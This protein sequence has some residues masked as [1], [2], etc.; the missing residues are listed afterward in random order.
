M[1]NSVTL[2]NAAAIGTGG[3]AVGLEVWA[4]GRTYAVGAR[5]ISPSGRPIVCRVAH[6]S[7]STFNATRW[8]Y[9]GPL[10]ATIVDFTLLPDGNIATTEPAFGSVS[11]FGVADQYLYGYV[12]KDGAAQDWR[13][14]NPANGAPPSQSY[15]TSYLPDTTEN[16]KHLWIEYEVSAATPTALNGG[17]TLILQRRDADETGG[18]SAGVHWQLY[19]Q[20]YPT[21]AN[22]GAPDWPTGSYGLP[23][24]PTFATGSIAAGTTSNPN[25]QITFSGVTGTIVPGLEL[26]GVTGG[27][28]LQFNAQYGTDSGNNVPANILIITGQVSGTVGGAGVYT[29]S[30]SNV[31]TAA[32][33]T[34]FYAWVQNGPV[35]KPP[36]PVIGRRIRV[37]LV[38]DHSSGAMYGYVDG[39]MCAHW[40]NTGN[41]AYTSYKGMFESMS[42]YTKVYAFGVSAHFPEFHTSDR[43]RLPYF[44]PNGYSGN[45]AAVNYAVTTSWVLAYAVKVGFGS[46]GMVEVFFNPFIICTSG[47]MYMDLSTTTA[48]PAAYPYPMK[49]GNQGTQCR[50]PFSQYYHG[51]PGTVAEVGIWVK[52]DGSGSIGDPNQMSGSGPRWRPVT[53]INPSTF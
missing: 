53:K 29:L 36:Y 46:S 47:T 21:P 20:Q 4:P 18:I 1:A 11:S 14:D 26:T 32:T 37:E 34:G 24:M 49:M 3:A 40:R 48:A 25:N 43:Q 23:A 8:T 50:V 10:N 19:G 9:P 52:S 39:I 13:A 51:T 16:I 31:G 7:A 15:F 38:I 22:S 2:N 27:S 17:M 28:F 42:I 30:M 12:I 41:T 33:A 44:N 45:L 5:T 35:V 6:T